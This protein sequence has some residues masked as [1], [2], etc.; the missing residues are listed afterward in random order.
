[1]SVCWVGD[2]YKALVLSVCQL[3]DFCRALCLSVLW[4]GDS[5]GHCVCLFVG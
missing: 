5:V 2:F 1:M 4:V 3:G